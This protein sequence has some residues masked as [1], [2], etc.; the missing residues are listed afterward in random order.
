MQVQHPELDRLLHQPDR[1]VD[2]LLLVRDKGEQH[3]DRHAPVENGEGSEIDHGDILATEHHV[4]DG[5]NPPFRASDTRI[6][7]AISA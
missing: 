3:P 6:G 2:K 1:L 4:V 7:A 5:L